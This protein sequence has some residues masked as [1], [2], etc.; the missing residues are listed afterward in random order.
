MTSRIA[1]P[2][3][4]IL[5]LG[6]LVVALAL[7]QPAAA[8]NTPT[9]VPTGCCLCLDCPSSAGFC[10]S[11]RTA[12]QCNDGCGALGC[13]AFL[14]GLNDTCMADGSCAGFLPPATP[15]QTE[16]PT[17]TETPTI[18]ETPSETPTA[19]QSETPSETPT[20]TET[21]TPSETPTVTET[22]T[23]SDTPTFTPTAT[24][25]STPTDTR[26]STNTPTVTPTFTPSSTPSSTPTA[27]PTSTPTQ[28]RTSTSTPTITPTFTPSSTRTSTPTHTPRPPVIIPG[29][30]P[31]DSTVPGNGQPNCS[32]FEVCLI[33][34]GGA[35]P[36]IPPCTA[37]DSIIG[38]GPSN[39]AGNFNIPISPPLIANQC[40]YVFDTCNQLVGPVA[41]ARPA[42][43]APAMSPRMT[44]V[45]MLVLGL[46]ALFSLL[47]LKRQI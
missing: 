35:D 13:N 44:V 19:T 42:A 7:V 21:Q 46:V 39:G 9:P 10:T 14:I 2:L 24:P 30:H 6:A 16:T 8:Q 3:R 45:A 41:C 34:G 47:R 37:P 17:D 23:P 5:A 15:T 27:T 32:L 18:T 11:G 25:T 22:A 28:T 31:G 36:S 40:I 26:T 1:A 20:V 43:P 4:P 29:V 12:Q 33:G 38:S